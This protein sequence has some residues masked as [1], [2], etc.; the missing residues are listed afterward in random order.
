MVL[1]KTLENLNFKR[2]EGDKWINGG[3][4]GWYYFSRI[5]VNQLCQRSSLKHQ[6]KMSRN[7]VCVAKIP[8]DSKKPILAVISVEISPVKDNIF[9]LLLLRFGLIY[10]SILKGPFFTS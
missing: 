7:P 2:L 4:I 3:I 5:I 10:I 6:Q 1:V 9:F 8:P